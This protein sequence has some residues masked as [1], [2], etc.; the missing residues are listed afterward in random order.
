MREI[1]GVGVCAS[2]DGERRC[3]VGGVSVAH[4]TA[5][6]TSAHVGARRRTSAHGAGVQRGSWVRLRVRS[7]FCARVVLGARLR[8]LERRGTGIA[9]R[10]ARRC[11]DA[12]PTR[13][14]SQALVCDAHGRAGHLVSVAAS[15]RVRWHRVRGVIAGGAAAVR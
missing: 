8:G 15:T 4:R 5:R 1:I 13:C 11:R 6:R 10:C 2:R 7:R 3:H 12:R 14:W 9:P